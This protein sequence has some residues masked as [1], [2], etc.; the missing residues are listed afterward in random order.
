MDMVWYGHKYVFLQDDQYDF[1]WN[2]CS[3]RAPVP[4]TKG[5]WTAEDVFANFKSN[6][7]ASSA[8]GGVGAGGGRFGKKSTLTAPEPVSASCKVAM[9]QFEASSSRGFS[10]GWNNA[11]INDVTLYGPS[12]LVT[13]DTKGSLNYMTATYMNSPA[14]REA[15]HLNKSPNKDWPGPGPK[16]SYTSDYAA[17]NGNA[18]PGTKSMVDFYREISPKMLHGAT[19]YNGDTDPCVS[20]EG[21]RNAIEAVG[22]AEVDGGAGHMR[23]W[24]FDYAAASYKTL[25]EKPLLFGPSLELYSAGPQFG[26]HVTTYE[27]KLRFVTVHGSGHMVPQFRPRA[28]LRM[29][30]A[31]LGNHLLSPL[32]LPS[33]NM[34][35]LTDDEY[36][37]WLDAWT[38]KAKAE[39]MAY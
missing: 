24:F 3:A 15:L 33:K 14:V 22:F 1:L 35:A 4:L 16:W 26:G 36:D 27:H 34:S 7:A 19:V 23:P 30:N 31:V 9:R 12:A 2:N 8:P 39:A 13:W 25:K 17:C 11:W 20:Y 38:V 29:L 37:A 18:A 32:Y 5:A 6:A 10:Q 21:T 28:T